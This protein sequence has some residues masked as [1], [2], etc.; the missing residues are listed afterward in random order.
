MDIGLKRIIIVF[1]L[2]FLFLLISFVFVGLGITEI[3]K[4]RKILSN[5]LLIIAGISFA[6]ISLWCARILLFY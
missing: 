4:K 6:L 2:E 5:S 3:K 1:T